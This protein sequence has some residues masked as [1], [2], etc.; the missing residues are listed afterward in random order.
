MVLLTMNITA[1]RML[2]MIDHFCI[3]HIKNTVILP[4]SVC[5]PICMILSMYMRAYKKDKQSDTVSLMELANGF[6]MKSFF[7]LFS[8]SSSLLYNEKE[9][10]YR[11]LGC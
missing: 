2:R 4:A 5:L 9:L 6:N 7:W 11:R 10:N 3:E 8:L 1:A